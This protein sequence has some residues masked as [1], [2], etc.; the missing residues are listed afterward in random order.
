MSQVERRSATRIALPE[1]IDAVLGLVAAR[2]VEISES[3]ARVEHDE[4]VVVF[5]ESVLKFTWRSHRLGVR[6]KIARSEIAGRRNNTLVYQ[7]GLQ[8]DTVS[9]LDRDAIAS[10]VS[11]ALTGEDAPAR[12]ADGLNAWTRL[13]AEP[14]AEPAAVPSLH[15]APAAFAAAATPAAASAKSNPFMRDEDEDDPQYIRCEL[16]DGE[17]VRQY[18]NTPE[19]PEVGFTVGIEQR[20]DVD[21][22]MK[23]FEMADPDTRVMIRAAIR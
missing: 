11:F 6:V 14:A 22:L 8:F 7:S 16:R 15:A 12:I 5:S 19:H 18:V 20:G 4:R 21:G 13:Q 23:T 17:W 9:E 3:G 10:L 2:L 1:P